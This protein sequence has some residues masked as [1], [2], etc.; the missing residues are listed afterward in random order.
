MEG[1]QA[2]VTDVN[3]RAAV[4]VSTGATR[5]SFDVLATTVQNDG[6]D[7]EL[8]VMVVVDGVWRP[9]CR[10]RRAWLNPNQRYHDPCS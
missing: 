9:R 1:V 8:P 10:I 2:V 4:R 5:T 7:L 3:G 6:T